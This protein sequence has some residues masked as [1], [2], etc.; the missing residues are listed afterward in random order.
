MLA[1][2][3]VWFCLSCLTAQAVDDVRTWTDVQGRTMQA[4][5][6]R[7]VDG[8]VSFLKDGKLTIV[9]MEKLSEKDQKLI[10]ELEAS[11]RAVEEVRPAGAPR[12]DAPATVT[13]PFGSPFGP[14]PGRSPKSDTGGKPSATDLRV[15]RDELGNQ[16][17]A[18]FV[19]VHEGN[20]ILSRGAR[21]QSL[22]FTSL[23]REDRQYLHDLLAARG[24]EHLLPPVGDDQQNSL[25][26]SAPLAAPSEAQPGPLPRPLPPTFTP[27]PSPP[28]PPAGPSGPKMAGGTFHDQTQERL[29]KQNEQQLEAARQ[30]RDRQAQ[31]LAEAGQQMAATQRRWLQQQKEASENAPVA[32]CGNCKKSLTKVQADLQ[33][34]PHCSV[35]WQYEVDR[36]GNKHEI[37]GAAAAAAATAQQEDAGGLRIGSLTE[38]QTMKLIFR[39]I[40][41]AVIIIITALAGVAARR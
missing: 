29:Q 9:P 28:F 15:W 14:G 26:N 41:P 5:F 3:Y 12:T 2:A 21:V 37:P 25:L 22:P 1:S 39:V 36:F 11:R 8:D 16:I 4:V 18:R 10:R 13:N 40:I 34:C 30:R 23:S 35:V 38:R 19:R 33:S 31:E 17:T 32:E 24:E 6:L 20:V 7:E 27:T